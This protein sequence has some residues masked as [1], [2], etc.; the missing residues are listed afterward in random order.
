MYCLINEN[1]ECGIRN[2]QERKSESASTLRWL[3]GTL[4]D[5]RIID[6]RGMKWQ[7]I[8]N[9]KEHCAKAQK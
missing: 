2:N 1:Y 9:V 7:W 3:D 4:K 5:L 6:E 8:G